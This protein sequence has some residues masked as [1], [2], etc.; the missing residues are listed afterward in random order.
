MRDR[1]ERLTWPGLTLV[2]VLVAWEAAT[3]GGLVPPYML[4]A[5][6]TIALR[7]ATSW[8]ILLP[9]IAVTTIE[10]VL[11]FLRAVVGGIALAIATA[12]LPVFER[13]IYPWIVAS[14]AIPKVAI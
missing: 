11:G 4:P 5:P 9:H 2:I 7:L 6:S 1:L 10:I 13:S 8:T 3:R 14:R 12:Y